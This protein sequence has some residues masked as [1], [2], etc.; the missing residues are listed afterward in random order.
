MTKY[1]LT[2]EK[3]CPNCNGRKKINNP[4]WDRAAEEWDHSSNGY[5]PTSTE[6]IMEAWKRVSKFWTDRGYHY[7]HMLPPEKID[8]LLCDATGIITETIEFSEAEL[9]SLMEKLRLCLS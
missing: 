8:C 6:E 1:F 4:L 7:P 3:P 9:K 2:A 5:V